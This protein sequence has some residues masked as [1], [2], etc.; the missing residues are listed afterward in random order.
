MGSLSLVRR[1]M[2]GFG[3]VARPADET[4][5]LHV[6][7]RVSL[8][9]TGMQPACYTATRAA[10]YHPGHVLVVL[11]VVFGALLACKRLQV[12]KQR[13]TLYPTAVRTQPLVLQA[14]RLAHTC[15]A[16]ISATHACR[17]VFRCTPCLRHAVECIE[18][19]AR[20]ECGACGGASSRLPRIWYATTSPGL[21][22]T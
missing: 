16:F 20:G 6:S 8:C 22:P 15:R 12:R 9:T 2:H 5:S 14:R 4:V 10:Y 13:H 17:V 19:G 7:L 3:D 18:C 1:M 11:F 21:P